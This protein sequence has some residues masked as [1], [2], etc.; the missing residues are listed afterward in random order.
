MSEPDADTDAAVASALFSPRRLR[1]ARETRM[2]TRTAVA[3]AAQVTPAAVSQFERGDARPVPKTL[4][5]LAGALDFPVGFFAVSAVPSSREAMPDGDPHDQ[6][7]FRS[8]RSIAVTDRRRALALSHLVHDL[9]D[10]L[11]QTVR[12]PDRDIP[13]CPVHP[14]AGPAAAENCAVEIRAA[15]GIPPGP[16]RNVVREMERHGVV[17]ARYH[18]G[19]HDVDAFSVPFPDWPVAVLGDDK[20][21]CDRERFSAAHELGHL[22]MHD[23][24]DAGTKAIEDQANR[25]AAAFLMP[26]NDIRTELPATASWRD[27]VMLKKRWGASIGT[28]LRRSM[29]L[30]IMPETTYLQAVRYMSAR[31]WRVNEPGDL[32]VGEAPQLLSL[33]ASAV[34]QAG[35]TIGTLASETGWPEPMITELLTASTDPRPR[36][37]L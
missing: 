18:A 29:T 37:Y 26:A 7:Y 11:S 6:G 22:V 24:R 20:A 23:I 19:T 36:I 31:G 1:L 13:H 5:R 14:E 21:K 17:C 34:K 12:L 25:F 3:L 2:M 35:L 4:L 16:I 27:L 9:A 33:A 32:G 28:L 10:R 8:L 30:N 15:W